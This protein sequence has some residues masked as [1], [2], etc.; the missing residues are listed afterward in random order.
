MPG[1]LI[2]SG[3]FKRRAASATSGVESS[4]KPRES[5]SIKGKIRRKNEN[6]NGSGKDNQEAR[7]NESKI[8]KEELKK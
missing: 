2:R 3:I 6:G 4:A 8:K 5:D 1:G 7:M